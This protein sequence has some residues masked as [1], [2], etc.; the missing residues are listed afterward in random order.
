MTI[1]DDRLSPDVLALLADLESPPAG[2]TTTARIARGERA[3]DVVAAALGEADP[4]LADIAEILWTLYTELDLHDK[5]ETQLQR[6]VAVLDRPEATPTH[7][8]GMAFKR[9]GSTCM[10]QTR[11]AEASDFLTRGIAAFERAGCSDDLEAGKVRYMLGLTLLAEHNAAGARDALLGALPVLREYAG[12]REPLVKTLRTLATI[13]MREEDPGDALSFLDEALEILTLSGDPVSDEV[14]EVGLDLV[15]C[16]LDVRQYRSADQYVR[17]MVMALEKLRAADHP[18]LPKTLDLMGEACISCGEHEEAR[19]AYERAIQVA[20][21]IHGPGARELGPLYTHLM[22]SHQALRDP[23]GAEAAARQAAKLYEQLSID[24]INDISYIDALWDLAER[25]LEAKHFDE[26]DEIAQRLLAA[27]EPIAGSS[28]PRVGQLLGLRGRLRF[29]RGDHAESLPLLEAALALLDVP[30]APPEL[31]LPLA[32]MIVEV[33]LF[34]QPVDE[35]LGPALDRAIRELKAATQQIE[36]EN[37]RMEHGAGLTP[38][39]ERS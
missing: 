2:E 30:D 14:F 17:T 10:Q 8:L 6:M 1:T 15:R 3:F 29:E 25:C 31:R 20:E 11:W 33:R 39:S 35:N 9:L 24:P 19:K 5:A 38:R 26:A 16:M 7:K 23:E 36:E 4:L 12:G 28:S 18:L 27:I 37:A 22:W 34:H 13:S 21:R 32:R